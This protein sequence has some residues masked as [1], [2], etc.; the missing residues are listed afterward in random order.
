MGS[1]VR[2]G[3]R[4]NGRSV[5]LERLTALRASEGNFANSL[6][7]EVLKMAFDTQGNLPT[8][9][10]SNGNGQAPARRK[11][12]W[13]ADSFLNIH[14]RAKDGSTRKLGQV[15]LKLSNAGEAD[16]HNYLYAGGDKELQA[17]REKALLGRFVLDFRL[18]ERNEGRAFDL[19]DDDEVEAVAGGTAGTDGTPPAPA[20]AA[21]QAP[22]QPEAAAPTERK[23]RK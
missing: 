20:P 7:S 2:A 4:W 17:K 23:P 21:P 13:Q 16:I 10:N 5:G 6:Y 11:E 1:N 12:V 18:A 8:P 14:M 15:P 9:R 22:E 19:P 3:V